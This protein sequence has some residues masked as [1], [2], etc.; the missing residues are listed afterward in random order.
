MSRAAFGGDFRRVAHLVEDNLLRRKHHP[1]RTLLPSGQ[2]SDN[3][4]YRAE[5]VTGLGDCK[6]L[7][8]DQG[9]L[10]PETSND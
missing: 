6:R 3:N 10:R 1:Y 8:F 2:V 5:A 9:G 4:R 7:A